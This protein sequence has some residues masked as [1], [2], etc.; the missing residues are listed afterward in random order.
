MRVLVLGLK[1]KG[2]WGLRFGVHYLRHEGRTPW[3]LHLGLGF[4]AEAA[5]YQV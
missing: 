2:L 3:D 4:K 1:A 5:G